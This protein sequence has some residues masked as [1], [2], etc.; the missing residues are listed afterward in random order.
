M[1][2]FFVKDCNL[3]LLRY[4]SGSKVYADLFNGDYGLTCAGEMNNALYF[5]LSE[6]VHHSVFSAFFVYIECSPISENS[7]QSSHNFF[8]IFVSTKPP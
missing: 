5:Y 4:C 3:E 7:A 8:R 6:N 2:S 1:Q